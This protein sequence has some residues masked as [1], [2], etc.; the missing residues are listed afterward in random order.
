MKAPF[1]RFH[2]EYVIQLF[3]FWVLG[4]HG[5]G[6]ARDLFESITLKQVGGKLQVFIYYTNSIHIV[7]D[8]KRNSIHK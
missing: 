5:M 2:S 7:V 1:D 3:H 6:F 4:F 8:E